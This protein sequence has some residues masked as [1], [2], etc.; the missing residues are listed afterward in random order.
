MVFRGEGNPVNGDP[1][2]TQL[3]QTIIPPTSLLASAAVGSSLGFAAAPSLPA[4][5]RSAQEPTD[6]LSLQPGQLIDDYQVVTLLGRGGFGAVY[7]AWQVSLGRQVALKISPCL[8]QEGRTLARLDHPHIVRVYSETV[9]QQTRLLC[10]QYVASIVLDELL[11][12]IQPERADWSGADLLAKI[13]SQ[14][15]LAA[16]FDPEQLADRQ[17][18]SQLDHVDACC[19]IGS[20]LAEALGHAHRHGVLHRDLKP[21]NVLLSQYGR[22]MLVDFNLANVTQD[23][24]AASQLFGGTLPYMSPEHLEAFDPMNP[25]NEESVTQK[26][27]VYSL[28]VVL[29]ELLTGRLPFPERSHVGNLSRRIVRMVE[30]RRQ[31][32]QVWQAPEWAAWSQETALQSVLQRAM[33]AD[34]ARRWE[35]ADAFSE[36]L[37]NVLDLRSTLG[38]IQ[39]QTPFAEKFARHPFVFLAIFGLLPHLM[40]SVVNITYNLLQVA[41]PNR[42]AVFNRLVL[43]YNVTL[44][45]L[46]VGLCLWMVAPI[47]LW[48]RRGRNTL[49][50]DDDRLAGLR[51]RVM[52][53][54]FHVMS[55]ALLGW[56]PGALW[57]PWGLNSWA[58]E[59]LS[60]SVIIHLKISVILSGL[61]ALTYSASGVSYLATSVFYPKLWEN[62]AGFREQAARDVRP[63]R[64]LLRVI[65]FLAGAIPLVGASLLITSSTDDYSKN[66]LFTFK[67][68]TTGL[69]FLGMLGFQLAVTVT[70]WTRAAVDAFS[71]PAANS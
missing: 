45:P 6:G 31:I 68:L 65:P 5:M 44:Y 19:W 63:L 23:S 49:A 22:P 38:R 4:D 11:E 13:D 42:M 46:C 12:K 16:E 64:S 29:F 25:A 51:R 50:A 40:G 7:L 62:P 10:M 57:F 67:V 61:I 9:H 60:W 41:G 36:A 32:E 58:A 17:H 37:S 27:D 59:S 66:E 1:D 55:I 18:L 2:L 3:Q 30:D 43:A 39:R 28:A 20:R 35:S 54:P 24:G 8:G 47:F 52:K 53:W 34:P 70:G 15:T 48:W 71:G 69:I 14:H 33:E 26:S 21:G 56:M